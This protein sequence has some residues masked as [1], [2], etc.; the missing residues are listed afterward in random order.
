MAYIKN[1]FV[2]PY[3][4]KKNTPAGVMPEDMLKRHGLLSASG[5]GTTDKTY[6]K[7]TQG[8]RAAKRMFEATKIYRALVHKVFQPKLASC[9]KH[10]TH[11]LREKMGREKGSSDWKGTSTSEGGADPQAVLK[12]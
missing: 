12:V 4:G 2:N 11:Y 7:R 3:V 1:K 10:G 9:L 6:A 8:D 5:N